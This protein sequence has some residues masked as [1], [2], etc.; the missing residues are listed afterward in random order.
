MGFSVDRDV[1]KRAQE[2]Q[3]FSAQE[4]DELDEEGFHKKI[5]LSLRLK[6]AVIHTDEK[7]ELVRKFK[8]NK[9]PEPKKESMLPLIK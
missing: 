1:Q 6:R 9:E 8:P 4:I 7:G 2:K 5:T 3:N